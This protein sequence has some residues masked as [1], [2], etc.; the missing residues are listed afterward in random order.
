MT[1]IAPFT[2]ELL[3][4]AHAWATLP[5]DELH[6]KAAEA[7]RDRNPAALWGLAEAWLL[8][9]GRAGA[10]VSGR[11]LQSYQEG[12]GL[13]LTA[14]QGENL[15]HPG[16]NAGAGWIRTLEDRGMSPATVRVRLAAA[17]T[18]YAALRWS[19]AT[20]ADPFRDVRPASDH[21]P[22]ESKRQP[23]SPEELHA[24]LAAADPET[25]LILYLGSMAGLRVSEILAL[26]WADIDLEAGQ[27]TVQHGK[28]GRRR[29]VILSKT[30]IAALHAAAQP[31]G[32]RE[33]VIA[34]IRTAQGIRARIRA[35]CARTGTT[36]RAAHALRHSAG[37]RAYQETRDLK[38]VAAHLGHSSI[39]T[40]AIYARYA[41]RTLRDSVGNW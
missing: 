12:I 36:N 15:L 31:A 25:A 6:R 19:G 39:D 21:T 35:L 9:Y 20:D 40:A 34:T 37:T 27:L 29:V 13:L 7:A 16:R 30:L 22:P 24:L 32:A 11:T 10:R 14:W 8:H 17:R 28:G 4:R 41:D 23:Y 3:T 2:G 18:L 33:P 38:A 1:A 5:A 26:Q